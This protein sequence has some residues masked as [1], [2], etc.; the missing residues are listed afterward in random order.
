M[1]RRFD[2]D[3]KDVQRTELAAMS[4]EELEA[5]GWRQHELA[6]ELANRLGAD[7]RTSSRPPSSDD[8][9]KRDEKE[10]PTSAEP[11]GGSKASSTKSEKTGRPGK[12]A[13]TKGFW[14][15]QTIVTSAEIHHAPKMCAACGAALG[16]ALGRR[17]VSAHNSLELERGILSIQVT[18]TKHVYFA[19]RCPCGHETV[20][21]PRVGAGSE[22]E[23]RRRDLQMSERCLVGPMLATYIAALSVRFRHSRRRIQEFLHDWLGLELGAATIN[24]CVHE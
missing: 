6:R 2:R 19:V 17:C 10:K 12:K 5:W 18:A 23:G 13:G 4:R 21:S 1:P 20:E 14:R 16:L 22:I 15:S 24:R 8:P 7:S 3:L 11:D 9:Y